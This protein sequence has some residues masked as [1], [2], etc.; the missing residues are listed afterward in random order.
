MCFVRI[1]SLVGFALGCGSPAPLTDAGADDAAAEVVDASTSAYATLSSSCGGG[2]FPHDDTSPKG[3]DPDPATQCPT[4]PT[5]GASPVALVST[6]AYG[7][8]ETGCE[9]IGG[10]MCP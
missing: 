3:C 6:C 2:P 10:G 9:P 5:A 8:D 1:L 4:A 7:R